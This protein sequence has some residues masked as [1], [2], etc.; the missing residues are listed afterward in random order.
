MKFLRD[1][2]NKFLVICIVISALFIFGLMLTGCRAM[3][4]MTYVPVESTKV[5]YRERQMLDSIYLHD[6]IFLEKYT[7]GD[8]VFVTKEKFRYLSKDKY[9]IDSIYITDTIRIPYPVEVQIITN[10]LN[11]IQKA[12]IAVGTAAIAILLFILYKKIF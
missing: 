7:K 3:A 2:A 9:V 1:D 4:K 5:E 6:S 12:L 10:E 8:T 11:R